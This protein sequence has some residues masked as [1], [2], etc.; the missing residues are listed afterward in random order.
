MKKIIYTLLV[1]LYGCF[2][3][4]QTPPDWENPAVVGINKEAYHST[5]ILPSK[6]AECKEI[7][8]LNGK[9][10]FHWSPNPWSRP[11]DFY[12][13]SFDSGSWDNLVVPGAWQLQGYGR[14]I[15][16][17]IAP[18]YQK[19]QPRVTSEPPK[20]YD[21]YE[22]RNP[23]GSYI[24]SFRVSPDMLNKRL[25][26]HFEGVKS[27]M[28]VWVNGT[29]VG[30]S[31]N[32]MSP[33]EFEVTDFVRPGE[34]SLAVEV[35][36]W[37]D[38]SYLEDQ[39]MWRLSGIFRPVELWVRPQINIQDY[40]ISA[41][42]SDDFRTAEVDATLW[43]RNQTKK[44]AKN[45]E[46]EVVLTGLDR[47]GEL[48]KKNF[49]KKI[50]PIKAW[51]TQR[52]SLSGL[53][54]NPALWSAEKPGLYDV[55]ITLRDAQGAQEVLSC[56][57]GVRKIEISGEI[58]KINGEPIKL[59]GV[60]RHEHHPRT[61]RLVDRETL[62]KDL[63]LMKQANIN[64]IRTAHY[65]NDPLFYELCDKYGFYVMD[66]ANQETHGYGIGNTELG[67]NPD[68]MIAHVDRAVSLVQRDKNHPCV[69][70]WSIGNEGGKG[71]NLKA[72]ADTVRSLDPSRP[73]YCDSDRS[74]SDV[75]DDGYLSPE[76][77]MKLGQEVSGRPVFMREYAHAMGNSLGN[78]KEFWEVIEADEGLLGGAIWDWVDQG[79]A[80]RKDG[81]PPSYGD[82]P[83]AVQLKSNEFWAYG[84][85][86]SDS[87]NDGAFCINGMI[88]PDRT[89]H[90][91]YYEVQKVYQY[92]DFDL[93]NNNKVRL[94]NKYRFT[95]LKEFDY[96]FEWLVNGQLVHNG[97]LRVSSGSTLHLPDIPSSSGEIYLNVY[98][99]LKE[100]T[101]WADKGFAI[102]REQFLLQSTEVE[103]LT[104]AGG[105]VSFQNTS[106]GIEITGGS[107]IFKISGTTGALTSWMVNGNELLK[108]D[109]EPYFWKPPN[110]NQ[111]R[112]NY[113]TR[114]GAWRNAGETRVINDV[115]V[116]S[117]EGIVTVKIAMSLPAIGAK[118][119]LKYQVNGQGLLQVEA[120]Y[121]PENKEIPLMP[122]FGMRMRVQRDMSQIAWYGRGDFE[123]YPDR[124][125]AAFLGTYY[126]SMDDFITSYIVPQDNANRCDTRWVFLGNNIGGIKIS[127]LQP[128]CF[129]AWPY[130]EEDLEKAG[131]PHDLPDR[132]FINLNLDL[133]I[134]GVGGNDSWGAQT[135]SKYTIDGN[136]P[137]SYG[138]ILE[139]VTR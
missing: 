77:L 31:Q 35:Y 110:D 40:T 70:F 2:L 41:D 48:V 56:H 130:T 60:N 37:S 85:D 11:A 54:N 125:T 86:F 30:Y 94:K 59:K 114:L 124:M 64:M 139:Y 23:V 52:I 38:G 96:T 18:P 87:P 61:G 68:W 90:P 46:A 67:D 78:L 33:A 71:M 4:A 128:L 3:N 135:L 53:L 5:L 29:K 89:P 12:K 44:I 79:I 55:S 121:K 13:P 69:I 132:N 50:D 15:Y 109:L 98:T 47:D 10:K 105:A 103:C 97:Q 137:Y 14:P 62:E 111:K 9:W 7:Y 134:K 122:K 66:E 95:E 99:R 123:N 119:E 113:E 51:S 104:A 73:V 108:G 34:N 42:V 58:L 133:T 74:V 91:H 25:Y 100:N 8:S 24:S 36:R 1:S 116:N 118:Y 57:L 21:S 131:H 26:L 43:I 39:D 117:Q 101:L 65:P 81:S 32:S 92:I 112:N 83:A 127:G 126:K 27:A 129:R 22:N 93:V 75:Y 16:T 136:R 102:A 80:T 82:N 17:N 28:Y 63:Q 115:N 49:V 72:M 84:G 6:K 120:F 76:K 107:G 20:E 88:A 19:D 106:E 138:Y 45:I